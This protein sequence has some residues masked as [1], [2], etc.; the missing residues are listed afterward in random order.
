M[1]KEY[2]IYYRGQIAI[3]AQRLIGSY[4]VLE[5]SR[6]LACEWMPQSEIQ[7]LIV[8]EV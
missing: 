2:V 6:F 7:K 4:I 8:C 5:N 1:E 3:Y